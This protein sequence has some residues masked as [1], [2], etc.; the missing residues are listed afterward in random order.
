MLP[1]RF[2]LIALALIAISPDAL[3]CYDI[4][5]SGSVPQTG[6][7][8]VASDSVI[9]VFV[10]GSVSSTEFD[11]QVQMGDLEIAGDLQTWSRHY[12]V[13]GE[14]GLVTFTPSE[15]LQP[16]SIV[17]FQVS[18]FGVT[19]SPPLLSGTFTVAPDGYDVPEIDVPPELA[20]VEV[21]DWGDEAGGTE[22]A[23]LFGRDYVFE[24]KP[25][26][27][28]VDSILKFVA[29]DLDDSPEEAAT[30]EPFFIWG[31]VLSTQQIELETF[32]NQSVRSPADDCFVVAQVYGRKQLGP[33]SDV[34]CPAAS[35]IQDSGDHEDSGAATLASEDRGSRGQGDSC[36]G[37]SSG[38]PQTTKLKTVLA[39]I[40]GIVG[41]VL[42]RRSQSM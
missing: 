37:C 38:G 19:A 13:T 15:P 27:R 39:R 10:S 11:V 2:K 12:G 17:S 25:G 42:L 41:L 16:A 26:A 22:C 18:E 9:Q 21:H 6:E 32:T 24:V 3:A 5:V 4:Y 35:G 7:T 28:R 8:S 36:S 20:R 40:L 33:V 34:V 29:A 30:S 14:I 23:E 1:L 31:P